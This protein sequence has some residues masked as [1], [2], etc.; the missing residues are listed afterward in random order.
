MKQ[1][2]TW[3]KSLQ[4]DRQLTRSFCL[5]GLLDIDEKDKPLRMVI[6]LYHL[7]LLLSY[8]RLDGKVFIMQLVTAA[9]RN[10]LRCYLSSILTPE[11]P[12]WEDYKLP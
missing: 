5:F 4:T 3:S 12:A 7:Y 11:H 8:P 2:P 9:K 6:I 10:S 1:C